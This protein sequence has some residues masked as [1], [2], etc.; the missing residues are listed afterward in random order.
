VSRE[1]WRIDR[2]PGEDL[3]SFRARAAG[4]APRNRFGVAILTETTA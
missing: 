3:A 2:N 1:G 4:A